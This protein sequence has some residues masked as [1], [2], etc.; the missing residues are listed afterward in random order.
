MS[1]PGLCTEQNERSPAGSSMPGQEESSEPSFTLR[2]SVPPVR[3]PGKSKRGARGSKRKIGAV[4]R[5]RGRGESGISVASK[6]GMEF[7]PE[8]RGRGSSAPERGGRGPAAPGRGGRGSSVSVRGG[9]GSLAARGGQGL[10]ALGG[11]RGAGAASGAVQAA[12]GTGDEQ[13]APHHN[14]SS[15]PLIV[16]DTD[17]DDDL[18]DPALQLRQNTYQPTLQNFFTLPSSSAN[19]RKRV[20]REKSARCPV[21]RNKGF[22]DDSDEDLCD[23]DLESNEDLECDESELEDSEVESNF[24]VDEDYEGW[25]IVEEGSE[26]TFVPENVSEVE[27]D[28]NLLSDGGSGPGTVEAEET[29]DDAEFDRIYGLDANDL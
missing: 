9:R 2:G 8:R 18:P 25:D 17:D 3:L 24:G 14:V 19:Q 4:K 21:K 13:H 16:S 22:I 27:E 10:V 28:S 26:H 12:D 7:V 20:G 5:G 15:S 1:A 23:E 29:F 6:G 11:G